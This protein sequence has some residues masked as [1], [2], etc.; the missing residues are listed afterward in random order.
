MCQS[1]R[2]AA[3]QETYSI[4][5]VKDELKG[6]STNRRIVDLLPDAMKALDVRH[7]AYS[8][9]LRSRYLD[10]VIPEQGADAQLLTDAHR[11]ITDEV[12]R[13][14]RGDW[15]FRDGPS[16]KNAVPAEERKGKGATSD[17]TADM[18]IAV[19][20]SAEAR[21]VFYGEIPAYGLNVQLIHEP[22]P[23]P[24]WS[25]FDDDFRDMPGVHSYRASV[26]PDLYPNERSNWNDSEN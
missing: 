14:N 9:A 1:E 5:S 26:F 24:V 21:D 3:N 12:N 6:V 7:A 19:M 4:E 11:A 18:A 13:L 22:T 25:I 15:V 8:E 16:L 20:S 23:N 17:P 2:L 10:E